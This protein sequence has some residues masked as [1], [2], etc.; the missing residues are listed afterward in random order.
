VIEAPR[1]KCVE[2]SPYPVLVVYAEIQAHYDGHDVWIVLDSWNNSAQGSTMNWS[3]DIFSI[4]SLR[5]KRNIS[6]WTPPL[7]GMII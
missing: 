4:S 5:Q 7:Y 2:I 1:R 3:F 6:V